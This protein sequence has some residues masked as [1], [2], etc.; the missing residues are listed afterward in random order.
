MRTVAMG[1]SGAYARKKRRMCGFRQLRDVSILKLTDNVRLNCVQ[2]DAK[3]SITC[4]IHKIRTRSNRDSLRSNPA[5]ISQA[6]RV[7]S[8][9][10]ISPATSLDTCPSNRRQRRRIPQRRIP[11][12]AA[13]TL[14][15]I[16][17]DS[18]GPP[19]R[20]S[21]PRKRDSASAGSFSFTM[22]IQK[23]KRD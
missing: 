2:V 16:N 12:K 15:E 11:R 4:R 10:G 5:N 13:K 8:K 3:R 20:C 9:Q 14:K 23:F 1:I 18:D 17:P 22:T 19:R 6:N 7:S 21:S